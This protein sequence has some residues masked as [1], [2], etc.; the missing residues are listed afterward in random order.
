[1]SGLILKDFYMLAK[2]MALVIGLL[3]L[4][5]IYWAGFSNA[6]AF[7]DFYPCAVLGVLPITLQTYDERDGWERYAGGLPYSRAQI[8]LVKY[9]TGLILA[10][11]V[12]VI[13]AAAVLILRGTINVSALLG[14]WAMG[15]LPVAMIMPFAF[16]LGMETARWCLILLLGAFFA[17][18]VWIDSSVHGLIVVTS[19][20]VSA[21]C[22][23]LYVLSFFLAVALYKGRE[24]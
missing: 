12:A 15:I 7:Y 13:R 8:V 9:I 20:I 24:L 14:G 18:C 3:L 2:N 10:T 21:V 23:A 4:F 1:M 5:I 19:A 6:D 17:A 16:R 22:A 11:G